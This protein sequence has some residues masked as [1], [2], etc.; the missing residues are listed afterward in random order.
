METLVHNKPKR[1]GTFADHFRKVLFLGTTFEHYRSWIMW[2]KDTRY[3]QILAKVFHK[4]KY[5]TNPDITHGDRVIAA[6]RKFEY[7]LKGCMSPHLSGTTL[8][9][10]ERIGTILN[11]ERTQ[12]VHSNL[13]RIPLNPPPPPP[14][15]PPRLHLSHRR[16]HTCSTGNP[17]DIINSAT[18][19]GGETPNSG[20]PS[21]TETFTPNWR[22][23]TVKSKM[24]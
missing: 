21:P 3:T 15:D 16:A 11:H 9:Q 14:P 18:S 24:N 7:A 22:T 6:S 1:R 20:S 5:I 12:T 10:L 2:M 4:H 17:L 13:Y 23:N 19:K 8:E